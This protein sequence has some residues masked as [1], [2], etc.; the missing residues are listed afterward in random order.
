MIIFW[1]LL[2]EDSL[3]DFFN[4]RGNDIEYN[5][6]FFSYAIIL[7]EDL[8]LFLN[9]SKITSEILQHFKDNSVHIIVQ[10]YDDIRD[11]LKRLV[12]ES[13]GKVWISKE[14]S[15][16]LTSL[17]PRLKRV[18][19]TSPVQLMKAIKNDVEAEGITNCHVRDGLAL[20]K[21]FAWLENEVKNKRTVTEL[22]GAA[23]LEEFRKYESTKFKSH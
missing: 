18:Q 7:P 16:S 12:N 1:S 9:V 14:S 3:P 5:P 2:I 10:N 6:V 23:R 21:Y 4:L 15:Y 17:V 11:T 8:Y 22:S 13:L 19:D 20:V